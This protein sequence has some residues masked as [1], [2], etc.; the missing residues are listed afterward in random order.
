MDYEQV[1]SR[2]A[3]SVREYCAWVEGSPGDSESELF[4]V[5]RLLSRLQADAV[6][7]PDID[8]E[9]LPEGDDIPDVSLAQ[10]KALVQRF[11]TFPFRYYWE[12][13]HP[14]TP[15]PEEPVCGDI[16]DD[17]LDI[18]GDLKGA[19]LAYDQGL[20]PQA[21]WHWRFTWGVHWGEHLTSALRAL[22]SYQKNSE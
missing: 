18:Y 9:D 12:I 19:L 21:V 15:E 8:D 3:D 4:D 7:L 1:V 17:F 20:R 14:I 13:F 5:F 6:I 16:V 10:K 22:Y 2:F 11:E